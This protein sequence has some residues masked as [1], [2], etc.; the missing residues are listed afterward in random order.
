MSEENTTTTET[1]NET[2]QKTF[3]EDYVK[4]LREEN[5]SHR[6]KAKQYVTLLQK[7]TGL[8]DEDFDEAKVTN[9]KTNYEGDWQKKNTEVLT[10]ANERLLQAEIKSLDGYD[11]KLVSRLL[12][13][14]K[15]TIKD[16]GTIEGLKESVEALVAEFP[17]IKIAPK[18]QGGANPPPTEFKGEVEK[19][20]D[21]Y[22][23]AVQQ[24]NLPLQ[25]ALKSKIYALEHKV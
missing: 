25:V 22:D 7:V 17:Q 13:R 5:K 12:D 8:Q 10:K 4:A 19:L 18:A 24:N 15:V 3:S 20:R 1:T 16:D 2:T 21:E 6:L 11:A 9:W 14:S 23:K